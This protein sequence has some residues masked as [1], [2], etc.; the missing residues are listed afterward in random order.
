[1]NC[2]LVVNI[3]AYNSL[4]DK[5]KK[6][7][8]DAIDAGYAALDK[9]YSAS[10]DKY[11]PQADKQGI[12][13]ITYS[14]ADLNAFRKAAAQPVWDQWIKEANAVGLPAQELLDLVL[15][16]AKDASK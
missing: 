13:K 14:E 10:I 5:N 2:P 1:V 7:L 15:K 4:S 8:T 3:D 11:T 12:K 16:T 6:I 9:A